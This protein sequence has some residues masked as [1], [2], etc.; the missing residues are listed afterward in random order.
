MKKVKQARTEIVQTSYYSAT[1]MKRKGR[2]ISYVHIVEKITPQGYIIDG[3]V[4]INGRLGTEKFY[5]TKQLHAMD[6]FFSWQDFFRK[7]H[8]RTNLP[9]N[10]AHI[11]VVYLTR[12]T[13]NCVWLHFVTLRND[14]EAIKVQGGKSCLLTGV[15][16]SKRD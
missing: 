14:N 2:G 3:P 1:F 6:F 12:I 5:A 13:T 4:L 8:S 10:S 7:N 15:V 16:S 11:F 9:K